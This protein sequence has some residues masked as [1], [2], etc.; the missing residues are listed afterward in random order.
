MR[1][2]S[3]RGWPQTRQSSGKTSEKRP[4][5]SFPAARS[6]TSGNGTQ[7]PR[8]GRLLEKTHLHLT[9]PVYYRASLAGN[10]ARRGLFTGSARAVCGLDGLSVE[11]AASPDEPRRDNDLRGPRY[12]SR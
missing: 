12:Y 3:R 5:E 4:Q 6:T 2:I 8:L 9:P 11:R 1:E 10:S 7:R